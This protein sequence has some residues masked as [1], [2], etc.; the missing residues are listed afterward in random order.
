MKR[1]SFLLVKNHTFCNISAINFKDIEGFNFKPMNKM[2]YDG[3]TVKKMVMINSSFVETVLKKK[4]K[5]RLELYLRF[6]ISIIDNDSDDTDITDLRTA[7]NDLTRY[8]EIIK[9]KYQ[10]FLDEKYVTFLLQ[11]IDLL[12]QELKNKMVYY[13]EKEPEEKEIEERRRSR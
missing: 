1:A 4:I 9:F 13:K 12:E 7:L 5:K 6:I 3:V 2:H 8:K 11:K 10:K